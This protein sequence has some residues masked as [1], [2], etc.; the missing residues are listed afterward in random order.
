VQKTP[1]TISDQFR[2]YPASDDTM[3]HLAEAALKY[4]EPG[5]VIAIGVG[6]TIDRFIDV[7]A[8]AKPELAGVV[9]VFEHSARQ[10]REYGI[11]LLDINDVS[12]ISVYFGG[13][14]Q[15]DHNMHV[16]TGS[17]GTLAAEKILATASEAFVC[18]VTEAK[19][20]DIVR[21]PVPIEV[22][23]MARS[24]VARQ[25]VRLGGEPVYREHFVTT[26]GNVLLDL[27]DLDLV[28]PAEMEKSLNNIAGIVATGL[29]GLRHANTILAGSETGVRTL[30]W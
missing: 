14:N 8:Q 30:T 13:A 11:P 6:S 17:G 12:E 20:V 18:L 16:I 23:P 4:I 27:Y 15:C 19:L 10:L 29:F 28:N 25:I 5:C 9:T 22:I 26:A 21:G 24:Y 1:G 2:K 3:I 7:L